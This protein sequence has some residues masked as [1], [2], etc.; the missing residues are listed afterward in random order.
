[1]VN[2]DVSWFLLAPGRQEG[3]SSRYNNDSTSHSL[4]GPKKRCLKQ[5]L[6]TDTDEIPSFDLGF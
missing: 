5:D 2:K 6:D 4:S 3:S 1:M